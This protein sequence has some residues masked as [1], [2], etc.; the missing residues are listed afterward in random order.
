MH[1]LR[2]VPT[3]A[4]SKPRGHYFAGEVGQLA[5]V[6]GKRIGQWA[7]RGY[8]RS[9]WSDESPRIYS[10]QDV[11]EAIVVHELE[12]MNVAPRTIGKTVGTLREMLG[13]DWPLQDTELFVPE[14]HPHAL[15]RSKTVAVKSEF[16]HL[17]DVVRLH[18]VLGQVDLVGI[19]RDLARGGWAARALPDLR[20]I[21]VNP[22]RLSG[23]PTIKG[24]RVAAS[25][26]AQIAN[27]GDEGSLKAGFGLTHA[28]V[29]DAVR[30][31]SKVQEYERAA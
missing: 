31:W 13:T 29:K 9:S 30:W 26:V 7:R 24:R 2:S 16:G 3:G 21:E 20:H 25:D 23:R 4:I 6:S 18:P 5:G 19:K 8:I 11:A 14:S 22:D 15:G 1:I 27:S 17:E 28:Q 10:Y 12:V